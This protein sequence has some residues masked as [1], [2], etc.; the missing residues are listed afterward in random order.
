MCVIDELM[1]RIRQSHDPI[2]KRAVNDLI[3]L[4]REKRDLQNQVELL[5]QK[6]V[7]CDSLLACH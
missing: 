7:I 4:N 6:A 3:R 1:A 5:T 2:N